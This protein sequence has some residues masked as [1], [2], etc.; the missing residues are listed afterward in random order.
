MIWLF[1][2][3][4]ANHWTS[5]TWVDKP[6]IGR[7]GFDQE[8]SPTPELLKTKGRWHVPQV[9][10]MQIPAPLGVSYHRWILNMR[11]KGQ[12]QG[13]PVKWPHRVPWLLPHLTQPAIIAQWLLGEARRVGKSLGGWWRGD[14]D[15]YTDSSSSYHAQCSHIIEASGI[16]AWVG[17]YWLD[18]PV[19]QFSQNKELDWYFSKTHTHLPKPTAPREVYR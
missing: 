4:T 1:L 5:W 15:G 3:E 17:L 10:G 11:K 2:W 12:I 6:L 16:P 19:S 14:P 7:H 18:Q 8:E 9:D 13:G